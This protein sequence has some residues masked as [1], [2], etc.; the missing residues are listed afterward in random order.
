MRRDDRSRPRHVALHVLHV[1]RRLERDAAGVEGHALADEP[2][3]EIRCAAER[4]APSAGRSGV[5]RCCC[6]RRRRATRP[7][8][9]H[10][11]R[12][13]RGLGAQGSSSSAA[14]SAAC[15][16]KLAGVR[17][18]AGRLRDRARGS[19]SP[20][21]PELAARLRRVHRPPASGARLPG[22]CSSSSRRR[23]RSHRTS[24]PSTTALA[25]SSGSSKE[26]STSQASVP[27]TL[28]CSSR[29][30]AAAASRR[31]SASTAARGPTPAA[32]HRRPPRRS[33]RALPRSSKPL[34]S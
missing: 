2:E 5:A 15:S 21:L 17:S 22:S 13:A 32:H 28:A 24:A 23:A 29:V 10:A 20:R 34:P 6:L 9:A 33:S 16:A 14:S 1:R 4:V 30:V 12:R 25:C 19:P 26:G 8:R 18:L 31:A 7:C 11:S 3:H 27:P